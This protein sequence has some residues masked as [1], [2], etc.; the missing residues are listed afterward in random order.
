ML[1]STFKCPITGR[2]HTIVYKNQ[3]KDKLIKYCNDLADYIKNHPKQYKYLAVDTEGKINV[4]DLNDVFV[5]QFAECFVNHNDLINYYIDDS[6]E[7]SIELQDGFIIFDPDD[8][9]KRAL[10]LIFSNYFIYTI[11]FDITR[12]VLGL[13]KLGIP[14]NGKP[15]KTGKVTLHTVIDTQFR[16]NIPYFQSKFGLK[17]V[18]KSISF[19][20]KELEAAKDQLEIKESVNFSQ[21]IY[22]NLG[23]PNSEIIATYA[24]FL[25]YIS[26]DIA[27]TA[28][29]LLPYIKTCTS[30][31]TMHS[32]QAKQLTQLWKEENT[33]G[34]DFGS[35]LLEKAVR[36]SKDTL[37]NP[38]KDL[39]NTCICAMKL[40]KYYD[41]IKEFKKS[42]PFTKQELI[43]FQEIATEWINGDKSRKFPAAFNLKADISEFR[44]TGKLND[45]F[46]RIWIEIKDK[47]PHNSGNTLIHICNKIHPQL[48]DFLKACDV[49]TDEEM[50]EACNNIYQAIIDGKVDEYLQN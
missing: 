9:V 22:E 2:T 39:Y 18:V 4:A 32:L 30:I 11:F 50:A 3:N 25:Q 14:I 7:E 27:F 26:N 41:A 13:Y 1:P 19:P 24:G 6:A 17:D 23:K 36:Y 16:P 43:Q 8:D 33:I 37:Q 21:L 35:I 29:S 28:L 48:Y 47:V 34:V 10:R 49:L 46:F 12:D 38:T 15:D 45:E 31:K 42:F 40:I 20:C 5:I 44:I